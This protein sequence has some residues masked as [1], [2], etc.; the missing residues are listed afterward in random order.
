MR[1][2]FCALVFLL[3]MT[4]CGTH[5]T[6]TINVTMD[7]FLY[8]PIKFTV[9][10]GDEIAFKVT[11]TGTIVH[12]FVIMKL[13]KSAGPIF[14][15]EDA[16]NIYWQVEIAPGASMETSFIAPTEPGEY[17]VV[18]SKPGHLQAG[19]KGQLFVVADE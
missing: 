6:N 1:K 15:G 4:S 14:G 11:N 10:P 2:L 8:D 18:C 5:P 7:D 19:M 12:D 3:V 17:E 9:S 16:A 13:G